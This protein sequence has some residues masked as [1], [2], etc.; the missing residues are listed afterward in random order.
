MPAV[1]SI[2]QHEED[3]LLCCEISHKVLRTDTVLEQ[4]KKIIDRF[5]RDHQRACEKELLG[6]VV[7]TRYNN[8]TYRID[9]IVWDQNPTSTFEWR[10]VTNTFKDY[11]E[12]K[13]NRALRD[14]KQPLLAAMPTIKERRQGVSGPV[15][16]VPELCN[17]TGTICR[18][19]FFNPTISVF[20]QAFRTKCGPTSI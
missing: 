9:D 8:K 13:Y 5:G 1:T 4:M 6:E 11:Y 14:M 3:V 15:L 16:L 7:M 20:A 10:G 18:N 12:E 2:R 19:L 17:M